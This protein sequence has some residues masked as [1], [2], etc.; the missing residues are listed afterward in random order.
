[1]LKIDRS[2]LLAQNPQIEDASQKDASLS[3]HSCASQITRDC[4]ETLPGASGNRFIPSSYIQ[5]HAFQ[6]RG[7]FTVGLSANA[8]ADLL[9]GSRTA[10]ALAIYI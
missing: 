7:P 6:W 8:I 3:G 2:L 5:M 4:M 10:P 9:I 1:M